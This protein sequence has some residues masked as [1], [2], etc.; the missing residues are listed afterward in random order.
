MP[1]SSSGW[2]APA[3]SSSPASSTT[4]NA[5]GRSSRPCGAMPESGATLMYLVGSAVVLGGGLRTRLVHFV[6]PRE[7][8]LRHASAAE[9][10]AATGLASRGVHVSRHNV[11]KICNT[12]LPMPRPDA[13]LPISR[14]VGPAS[15]R[16]RTH[17]DRLPAW[18]CGRRG[19][20]ALTHPATH[21]H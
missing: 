9:A 12:S 21:D 17:A 3:V 16:A 13:M 7:K 19:L 10:A 14:R 2:S 20:D 15:P 18:V 6:S 5:C 11:N 4:A 1:T 8:K